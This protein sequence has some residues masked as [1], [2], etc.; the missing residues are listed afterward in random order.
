MNSQVKLFFIHSVYLLLL[1]V[2]SLSARA[3]I[4]IGQPV[5]NAII[6]ASPIDT[7]T[8]YVPEN[9]PYFSFT[10]RGGVSSE[11][12]WQQGSLDDYLEW[13]E[14][15]EIQNF[16]QPSTVHYYYGFKLN[17]SPV[18]THETKVIGG[19]G[20]DECTQEGQ[21]GYGFPYPLDQ[22]EFNYFCG[23]EQFSKI[24]IILSD[25][26]PEGHYELQLIHKV[27]FD[28]TEILAIDHE[29]IS[30][31]VV[32]APISEP[33]IFALMVAGFSGFGFV[34]RRNLQA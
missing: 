1:L 21:S 9:N 19:T 18:L 33:S 16:N 30:F 5:G 31:D 26:V 27:V 20:S 13:Y 12:Q 17:G 25:E 23:T 32:A 15:G 29:W 24:D 6:T 14:L 28:T 11:F 22:P 34:R 4:I 3:S 7:H 2:L 8:Y 10:A